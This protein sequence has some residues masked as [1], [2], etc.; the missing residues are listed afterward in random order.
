MLLLSSL[1]TVSVRQLL[2]LI[3]FVQFVKS[4][5]RADSDSM[6]SVTASVDDFLRSRI[7]TVDHLATTLKSK[8][9]RVEAHENETQT[10]EGDQN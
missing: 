8:C 1:A 4:T 6:S 10:R 9:F 5:R 3:C 7:P 2:Y